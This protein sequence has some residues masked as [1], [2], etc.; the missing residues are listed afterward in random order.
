MVKKKQAQKQ[1][2]KQVRKHSKNP[3]KNLPKA[4]VPMKRLSATKELEDLFYEISSRGPQTKEEEEFLDKE[5]ATRT[6]AMLKH[7]R[8]TQTIDKRWKTPKPPVKGHLDLE[9]STR[10]GRSDMQYEGGNI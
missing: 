8:K 6:A 1:S 9:V 2:K 3:T 4:I 7:V 5:L 10:P